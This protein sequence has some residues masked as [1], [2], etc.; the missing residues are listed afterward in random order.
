MKTKVR[1]HKRKIKK[2]KT[3]VKKHY[4]TMQPKP[5]DKIP[6]NGY[7]YEP[8]YDGSRVLVYSNGK[9]KL[10]NRRKVN[11]TK[12]YPELQNIKLRSPAV[13]DGEVIIQDKD[14]PYGDFK[15]L[16]KREHLK[17]PK[18]IKARSKKMPAKIIAFDILNYKGKD[19]LKTPLIKRKR[20]LNEVVP[21]K[22]KY[23]K[24]INYDTKLGKL[25]KQLK[26]KKAEGLVAKD[27]H[28]PYEQKD[29][30][31]WKK[32]KFA[33]ASDL[34]ILGYTKGT[35]KRKDTFGAL[36]TGY[37]KRGR[38]KF[39]GKVGTGFTDKKLKE[40]KNKMDKYKTQKSYFHSPEK[41]T[42][43]KPKMVGRF[44]YSRLTPKR[45]MREPRFE[46][47]RSDIPPKRTHIEK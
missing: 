18:E 2:G 27:M 47:L 35:G 44:N 32:I 43:L 28:S 7:L 4:R 46:A 45:I 9:I 31:H 29:S 25:V 24:E 17:D 16:A 6:K 34:T 12:R 20:I 1:K 42:W 40:L 38:W 5:S 37:P 33:K 30:K 23:I 8:K 22:Q 39:T 36:I 14:N 3:T 13:V 26:K 41:I 19:I 11:T 15:K 10:I 21:D